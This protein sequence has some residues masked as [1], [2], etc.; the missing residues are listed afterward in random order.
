MHNKYRKNLKGSALAYA[1]VIMSAVAILLTSILGFI[2]SQA[3]YSMQRQSQEEALRIAE[4]GI[5]FYKWYLAHQLN[6][7][8]NSQIDAFW[9]GATALGQTTPYQANYNDPYGAAIGQYRLTVMPPIPGSTII[10]VQSEGW[11]SKYPTLKKTLRVRLRRPSWSE[12]AVLANDFMRFG[13]GT[14]VYGRIHSNGGIRFDGLTHNVISSSLSSFD[15]PDHSGGSE[16][17]VHTHVTPVDPLPPA[18]V[19]TRLDV[20]EAGRSFPVATTDFNGVLGDLNT[21]KSEAQA[22]RGRYFDATGNGRQIT[23]LTDGTFNSCTVNNYTSFDRVLEIGTNIISNYKGVVTGATGGS[24]GTN[25]NAC[26]A[27]TC[28]ASAACGWIQNSNHAKGKCVSLTNYP[29][30]DHGVIF[31]ENNIWLSGQ[32]N[33][34]KIT[35]VGANISGGSVA[36]VFIPS[37]LTYTN[38]DG[39]DILGIIGQNDIEIP[40]NSSSVLRIDGALLAQQGRIGAEHYGNSKTSITV[41]G[42]LATNQ[43]YGFSWTDGTGYATRNLYYDNNLLYYPPPYFPTGTQYLLDLWEEL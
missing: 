21:M 33:A 27:A 24:S 10:Y 6:G 22:G 20:F 35:I 30:V 23:L 11:T 15:D 41:N 37:N 1:L 39:R 3:K 26:V 40:S 36:S 42:A 32:I 31:V 4:S 9:A 43:R 13:S 29:I 28:C 38:Y 16:F 12:S 19:P 34:K 14:E 5:H 25:G 8:T 17:G 2:S 7:R 18:A